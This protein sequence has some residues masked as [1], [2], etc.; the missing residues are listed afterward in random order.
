MA[1]GVSDKLWLLEDIAAR[2]EARTAKPATRG[3]YKSAR[4]DD[5]AVI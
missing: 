2:I 4:R 3:P 5:R 1:A